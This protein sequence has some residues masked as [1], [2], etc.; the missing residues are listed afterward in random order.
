M[1]ENVNWRGCL[2]SIACTCVPAKFD[3]TPL[4]AMYNPNHRGANP[5]VVSSREGLLR[6]GPAAVSNCG[7]PQ[8]IQAR[9]EIYIMVFDCLKVMKLGIAL[10]N[11]ESFFASAG[12]IDFMTKNAIFARMTPYMTMWLPLGYYPIPLYFP[13]AEHV[14]QVGHYWS[15]PFYSTSMLLDDSSDYIASIKAIL[16]LVVSMRGPRQAP[17]GTLC[18]STRPGL[19]RSSSPSRTKRVARIG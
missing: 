2:G 8:I 15:L 9:E 10:G 18:R 17:V 19:R 6:L 3:F 12:G 4:V 5:W 16:E 14:P 1:P 11:L 7:M 13:K